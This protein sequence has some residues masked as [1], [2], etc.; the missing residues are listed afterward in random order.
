M[1]ELAVI[2]P[3]LNEAQR[4]PALLAAL[5]QQ[6]GLDREIVVADGG[7]TDG[8]AQRAQQ[9]GT[10][11]VVTA[12]GRGRQMNAAA[13]TVS[14][15]YLL[16]LHADSCPE[17]ADA[18]AQA[19]SALRSV[20]RQSGHRRVAGH[21]SLRFERSSPRAHRLG[22]RYMEEKSTLNRPYCQNGDQGLLISADYFRE[23]GGF[24]ESLPYFEDLRLAERIHATGSWITLPGVMRSSARRF[25]QEGFL[26]R[27]RLMGLMVAAHGMGLQAFFERA[28]LYSTQ[29]SQHLLLTPYLDL[30][31]QLARELGWRESWRR[32]LRLGRFSRQHWWQLFFLCDVVLRPWLGAGRYPVLRFYDRLIYPL[33]ANR[34]GDAFTAVLAWLYGMCWLRLSFALR[35]RRLPK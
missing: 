13:R 30:L 11:V 16:F 1:S 22:Y 26:A 27:Y 8:T 3:A 34:L 21:F 7:S 10:R 14:A 5:N 9:A 12:P 2:I 33:T 24:D 18:L 35:E 31:R 4:L 25:E 32:L 20:Q 15:A 28:P 19:L 23:L 17:P 29:A 6:T